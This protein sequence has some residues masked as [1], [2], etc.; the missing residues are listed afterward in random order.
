MLS[1]G[2]QQFDDCSVVLFVPSLFES[3]SRMSQVNIAS[4][5]RRSS[6]ALLCKSS[7]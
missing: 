2:L 3:V 7:K 6:L 1:E 5:F 4:E